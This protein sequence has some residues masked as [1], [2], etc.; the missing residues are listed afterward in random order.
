M[1]TNTSAVCVPV[2]SFQA[3]NQFRKDPRLNEVI[4]GG[5]TV[6]GQQL[7]TETKR[8]QKTITY[9]QSFIDMYQQGESNYH[10]EKPA[11]E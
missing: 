4:Y 3:V 5:I 8:K 2:I 10:K 9:T 7:P 6:T 11:K 1:Q